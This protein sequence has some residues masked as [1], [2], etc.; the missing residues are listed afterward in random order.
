[1]KDVKKLKVPIKINDVNE[2]NFPAQLM[3]L[4]SIDFYN[5]W[6]SGLD[7]LL[8]SFGKENIPKT[9]ASNN[10]L[11]F[12]LDAFKVKDSHTTDSEK[13]YTNWFP[14][15]LPAKLYIHKASVQSKLDLAKTSLLGLSVGD[16]F[17]ETFFGPIDDISLR[18][19]ERILLS[20]TW[21]FTD[22]TVMAIDVYNVLSRFGTIDQDQLAK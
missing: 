9:D 18:V 2:D 6:Q 4:N 12:W 8:E 22:D 20:C 17:G 14:Y 21:F 15:Q 13:I 11:N 5:N 3:G 1:M 16:A 19:N 10:P 7:K